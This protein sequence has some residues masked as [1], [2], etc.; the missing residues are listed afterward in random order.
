MRARAVAVVLLAL[1]AS[2]CGA[3]GYAHVHA[4]IGSNAV[5]MPEEATTYR[6]ALDGTATRLPTGP[7]PS[8][9]VTSPNGRYRAEIVSAGVVLHDG[10]TGTS[11][12]LWRQHPS[13]AVYWSTKGALAF[14]VDELGIGELVVFDPSTGRWRVV[15]HRVCD[16]GSD[17]WSPDGTRLAVPV[18]LP[19]HGCG[20]H[21]LIVV[22]V[23]DRRR[24]PVRRIAKP[25]T[26]P[27]AWTWDGSGLLVEH[28]DGAGSG[29]SMLV[30]PETGKGRVVLPSYPGL[31]GPGSWSDG[32]RFIAVAAIDSARRGT[33]LVL[34][35]TL[36]HP[37]AAFTFGQQAYAWA[38]HRQ[39]LAVVSSSR[40]RVFDA[41]T[42]RVIATIPVKAPY[43][44][45]VDSLTWARDERSVTVIAAPGLGHD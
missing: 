34:G 28:W 45:G 22:A 44:F 24:G 25:H 27:V 43:G 8:T 37:V 7:V 12:T 5:P 38:P 29:T 4:T 18:S 15:A 42:R 41:S 32:R 3:G 10:R 30:D 13:S 19:H 1:V 17:P 31:G 20:G 6:L 2:A 40:I 36:V 14:T 9:A 26:V 33:L 35:R 21:G 11:R 23:A 16:S 39:W